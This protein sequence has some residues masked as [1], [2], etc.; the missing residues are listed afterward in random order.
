LVENNVSVNNGGSGIHSYSADH[1]DIIN[2]TAYHNGTVVGY[3]DIFSNACKDV[4]II[5]NLIYS[6][7]GGDCNSK[8]KNASEI[9]NF[10][11]YFNGKVAAQG[12]NDLVADPGFVNLSTDRVLGNFRLKSTSPAVDRGSN[13]AGQFSKTDILGVSRP[14]GT[15]P[16]IGAY[17]FT[18]QPVVVITAIEEPSFKTIV[19]APNPVEN[20]VTINW[21]EAPGAKGRFELLNGSGQLVLNGTLTGPT[22]QL[23][24]QHLTRGLYVLLIYR[25]N[26]LLGVSKVVRQ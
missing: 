5:N 26:K 10:N 8:P 19:V 15:K 12:P 4:N 17:E 16:D 18:N 3:P 14:Q 2:N 7:P 21:A 13:M 1:V 23:T 9:Y 22:H 20:A 24:T 25:D 6:R 11:V